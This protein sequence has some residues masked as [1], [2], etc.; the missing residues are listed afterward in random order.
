[1]ALVVLCVISQLFSVSQARIEFAAYGD[2]GSASVDLAQTVSSVASVVPNRD[3]VI[4]LGDNAYPAGFTSVNDPQFDTFSNVVASGVSYPHYMLLGNHDYVGSI[5]A[6][7]EYGTKD[8]RWVL[9]STYYKE[10]IEKDGVS[11]CLIMIDTVKFDDTQALWLSDQ[12][13]QSDCNP[14][15][16]WV[17]VNGHYPIWS[18]GIYSDSSTLKRKLLP[19]LH[20]YGVQLYLC[21]HEHLHEVLYDG[22]VVQVVSGASAEPRS[23][24]T[25]K[26]H[27]NMIWGASGKSIMGF[28]HVTVTKDSL[29]VHITSSDSLDDLLAFSITRDATK[30]SMFSHL[31]SSNVAL[32]DDSYKGQATLL[33]GFVIL[34]V[35]FSFL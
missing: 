25:F 35:G 32:K 12:L 15:T 34:T 33:T 24:R 19:I 6:Q 21:G 1:M 8:P 17:I 16:H 30:Q 3:F 31:D 7:I 26:D 5:S 23:G 4:L 9:P 27:P 29:Q 28:I 22:K 13:N 20:E 2:W 11:L 10:T 18:A 14:S